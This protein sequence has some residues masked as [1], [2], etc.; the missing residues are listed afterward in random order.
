MNRSCERIGPKPYQAG[1]E[2]YSTPVT[3]IFFTASHRL[4]CFALVCALAAAAEAKSPFAFRKSGADSLELSERG[5][6]VYVYNYGMMLAN[7]APEDRRRS[8]YVHPVYAPDGAILTDDFP[9]DHYHHRGIFW[10]WPIVRAGGR[11][12][13][14]WSID[15][16][17]QKFVRWTTRKTG[18]DK[19]VLGVENG[20]YVGDKKI[21]KELVEITA[22][23]LSPHCRELRF[24]LTFEALHE[25]V[26]LAGEPAESKGYG[27]FC[28]RFAPREGT[29]ISTDS[30][31]ESADT[32]MAPH[33]W[34]QLEATYQGRRAGLRID[35]DPQNPGFPNGWCLRHYGFLGVN[36]P[37]L[38][39]Y[40]LLPS[41]PLVLKYTLLLYN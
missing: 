19:A 26:E 24:T 31:R 18:P 27:G 7:G 33:A 12:Y 35:I 14:L 8:T 37:G 17:H 32:N 10:V 38:A 36:F 25:P 2:A 16:I 4:V 34:A 30:G 1:R 9:R 41:R 6:P 3:P 40:T 20:W 23:S 29:V 15:G 13:D 39:T 11:K 21:V 5:K 28:V 22:L